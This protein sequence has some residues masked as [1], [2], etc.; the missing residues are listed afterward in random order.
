MTLPTIRVHLLITLLH[1]E[2]G[3]RNPLLCFFGKVENP[4]NVVFL[5]FFFSRNTINNRVCCSKLKYSDITFN[6]LQ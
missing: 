1:Q 5:N 3:G 6:Y 4:L 2:D